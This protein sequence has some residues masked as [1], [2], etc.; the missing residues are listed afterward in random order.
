MRF[1]ILVALLLT[2]CSKEAPPPAPSLQIPPG[3]FASG[4][5]DALCVMGIGKM[6]RAGFVSYGADDAN[7]SATGKIVRTNGEWALQPSGDAEC[8]IALAVTK[9]GITLGRAS[10]ACSY[11]CAPGVS[12]AGKSFTRLPASMKAP[13][14]LAG[15]PLC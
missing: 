3:Y 10:A 6:Q 15:D 14:D 11:Y 13:S 8:R 12:F 9:N 1:T 2:A 7:C 5:R 4:E